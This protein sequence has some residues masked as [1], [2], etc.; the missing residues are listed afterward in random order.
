[1]R[2]R[3]G[4][5]ARFAGALVGVALTG[6]IA[7]KSDRAVLAES[8][9]AALPVLPIGVL[10]ELVKI[11]CEAVATRRALGAAGRRIPWRALYSTHVVSTAVGTV[12]PLPRPASE[13]TKASLLLPWVALAESTSSGATMQAATFVCMG[14]MSLVCAAALEGTMR[15]ALLGNAVFLLTLGVG[16]RALIRSRKIA[17]FLARR[18]PARAESIER[19]HATSTTGHLVPW[20]PSAALI[21][22]VCFQIVEVTIV[23]WAVGVTPRVRGSLAAFGIHLLTASAAVLVPGQLGAREAAFSYSAEILGTSPT[24]AAAIAL[25]WHLSQLVVS[26]LGFAVL[27]LGPRGGAPVTSASGATAPDVEAPDKPERSPSVESDR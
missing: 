3:L 16:I 7:L 17:D 4:Q 22:G 14:T 23:A 2:R 27:A 18:F 20:A 9:R 15:L 26:G 25:F 10:L 8:A 12:L 21:V 24:R 13:A 19:F 1:M 5:M 6:W 11:G